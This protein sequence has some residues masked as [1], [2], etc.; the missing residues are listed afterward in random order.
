MS[1]PCEY[2]GFNLPAGVDRGTRRIRSAHFE[3]HARERRQAAAL[4]AAASPESEQVRELEAE[5]D[6][7]REHLQF[8]ERWSV[9]HGAKP[10]MTAEQALA[11]IQ[12]YP[13]IA[14][15]TKSY[16]DGKVPDTPD[17][18]AERDRLAAECAELRKDVAHK[19]LAADQLG[20]D[21]MKAHAECEALRGDAALLDWLQQEAKASPTGV[22][23]DH[24]KYVED[25]QVMEKGWRVMRRHFLGERKPSLREAIRA[26][27]DALVAKGGEA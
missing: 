11:V 25:S 27:R 4:Q 26:A 12:H 24:V 16:A 18:W 2:C 8:V 7:L 13:P 22:G 10:H 9:H 5:R 15:I 1:A 3:Q 6:E 14:D 23:L 19:D 17:P 20:R 21:L